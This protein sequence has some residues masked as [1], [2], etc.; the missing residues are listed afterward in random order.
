[1]LYVNKDILHWQKLGRGWSWS[2][3]CC[4][5]LCSSWTSDFHLSPSMP[6]T[7]GHLSI[8]L[9]TATTTKI[10]KQIS[11]LKN[12]AVSSQLPD[13]YWQASSPQKAPSSLPY[14]P[15]GWGEWDGRCWPWGDGERIVGIHQEK[16][17]QTCRIHTILL[18][19]TLHNNKRK[20]TTCNSLTNERYCG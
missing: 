13:R 4:R 18:V 16:M 14:E 11:K 3:R 17:A 12:H 5:H 1:M 7:N 20:K 19:E 9:I 2:S 15:G 10:N 6:N 8:Q